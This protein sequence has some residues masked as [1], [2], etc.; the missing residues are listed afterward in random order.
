M[1]DIYNANIYAITSLFMAELAEG[2][3]RFVDE[4]LNGRQ[5]EYG[6]TYRARQVKANPD[7]KTFSMDIAGAYPPVGGQDR[8]KMLQSIRIK[9]IIGV[10]L[11]FQYQRQ[12]ISH[13]RPNLFINQLYT[14]FLTPKC[15]S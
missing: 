13:Q 3:G 10:L 1:A 5:Q 9:K 14:V 4:L 8:P 15:P 6:R 12:K 7:K 11:L 2:K